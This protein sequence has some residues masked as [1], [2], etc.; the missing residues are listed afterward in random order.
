M[1]GRKPFRGVGLGEK[2]G[3]DADQVERQQSRKSGDHPEELA[4][5][6]RGKRQD[7]C[8]KHPS[9][10]DRIAALPRRRDG[11]RGLEL[12]AGEGDPVS[13][14]IEN[15]PRKPRVETEVIEEQPVE[16]NSHGQDVIARALLSSELAARF[17]NEEPSLFGAFIKNQ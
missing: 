5:P 2:Q 17:L 10:V 16:R 4:S 8:G 12:H 6:R 14:Q 9:G 13:E 3:H 1:D 11:L 7:R 15:E